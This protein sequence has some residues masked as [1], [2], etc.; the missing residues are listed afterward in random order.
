VKGVCAIGRSI[1]LF[2]HEPIGAT[3]TINWRIGFRAR[4]RAS[5]VVERAVEATVS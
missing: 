2:C 4:L 1:L 3:G 5:N